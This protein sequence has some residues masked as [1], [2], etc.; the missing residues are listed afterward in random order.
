MERPRNI[1]ESNIIRLTLA[2]VLAFSLSKPGATICAKNGMRIKRTS[3]IVNMP[4]KKTVNTWFIILR[5]SFFASSSFCLLSNFFSII[6]ARNGN[7]T[8]IETKVEIDRDI[9]VID[10]KED[11]FN[12]RGTS[13]SKTSDQKIDSYLAYKNISGPLKNRYKKLGIQIINEVGE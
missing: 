3:E 11:N 6:S 2:R 7:K 1:G 8:V 13:I 10:E 12:D 4:K 5:A 9:I